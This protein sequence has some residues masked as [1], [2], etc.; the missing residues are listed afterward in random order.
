V[1][2]LK[3][4]KKKALLLFFF[5]IT[6]GQTFFY[7][8]S[9]AAG[10]RRPSYAQYS[11]DAFFNSL[12]IAGAYFTNN[13]SNIYYVPSAIFFTP[14]SIINTSYSYGGNGK[15]SFEFDFLTP[16][17]GKDNNFM[18]GFGF[19]FSMLESGFKMDDNYFTGELT[20]LHPFE[21][22]FSLALVYYLG[23]YGIVGVNVKMP[24]NVYLKS[25]LDI[26]VLAGAFYTIRWWMLD[27]SLGISNIG[28]MTKAG[29]VQG[30]Y[31][32]LDLG[33]SYSYIGENKERVFSLAFSLENN[34]GEFIKSSNVL[35]L[36]LSARVFSTELVNDAVLV[37]D[38]GI[39][40]ED[41]PKDITLENDFYANIYFNVGFMFY[42]ATH[43]SIGLSSAIQSYTI[44]LGVIFPSAITKVFSYYVSVEDQF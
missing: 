36:A 43:F 26:G 42:D 38:P 25:K 39:Y 12:G 19:N 8:E 2:T 17:Q 20:S 6:M 3:R 9:F 14:D 10:S 15:N 7:N 40:V 35:G 24:Y 27:I 5:F 23:D 41:N 4:K 18:I 30:I 44:N 22:N 11:Y 34:L 1:I 29:N 33:I 16:I 37:D 21:G 28:F 13:V 31:P 32:D